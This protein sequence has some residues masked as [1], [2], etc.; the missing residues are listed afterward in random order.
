MP[1]VLMQFKPIRLFGSRTRV[2]V[3]KIIVYAYKYIGDHPVPS[4]GEANTDVSQWG[5][6]CVK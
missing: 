6:S 2:T 5:C 3:A 1:V 4:T